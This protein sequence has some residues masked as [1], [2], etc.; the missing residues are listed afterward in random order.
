MYQRNSIK[1]TEVLDRVISSFRVFPPHAESLA[2]TRIGKACLGRDI[3]SDHARL[4]ELVQALSAATTEDLDLARPVLLFH[5]AEL[6][7]FIRDTAF[8]VDGKVKLGTQ[9][10]AIVGSILDGVCSDIRDSIRKIDSSPK[11]KGLQGFVR[12]SMSY[13]AEILAV[14]SAASVASP[15]FE[16]IKRKASDRYV[17][18]SREIAS[19]ASKLESAY[20]GITERLGKA[21]EI[22]RDADEHVRTVDMR[23]PRLS[24]EGIERLT[25]TIGNRDTLWAIQSDEQ[26][27]AALHSGAYQPLTNADATKIKEDLTFLFTE[28]NRTFNTGGFV[29]EMLMSAAAME[30]RGSDLLTHADKHTV[31]KVK[32]MKKGLYDSQKEHLERV[33]TSIADVPANRFR[34]RSEAAEVMR[35]SSNISAFMGQVAVELHP[36]LAE[37]GRMSF[38]RLKDEVMVGSVPGWEDSFVMIRDR[39]TTIPDAVYMARIPSHEISV[40]LTLEGAQDYLGTSF[41][42]SDDALHHLNSDHASEFFFGGRRITGHDGFDVLAEERE[43]IRR[44]LR[45]GADILSYPEYDGTTALTMAR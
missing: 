35:K 21:D 18:Y 42:S 1:R 9:P 39:S 14:A 10:V 8:N 26:M 7:D 32:H 29:S 12:G 34:M 30:Y 19:L 15:E 28:I 41:F 27:E 40:D 36:E 22:L 31:E 25:W 43:R 38:R 11:N 5:I 13:L 33:A 6:L 16:E 44:D 17:A 3:I 37:V 24:S 20:E 45:D 4:D 2:D 23:V